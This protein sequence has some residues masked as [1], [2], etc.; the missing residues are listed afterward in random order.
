MNFDDPFDRHTHSSGLR[1]SDAEREQA[2][3]A[4]RRSHTEGRLNDAEFEQ[5]VAQAYSA[6]SRAELE[7]LLADLPSG[8]PAVSLDAGRGMMARGRPHHLLPL[9]VG[10][11]VGLWLLRSLLFAAPGPYWH[12][13]PPFIVPLV[14][15]FLVWRLIAR[16]RRAG[17]PRQWF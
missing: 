14:V 6:R 3:D 1:A 9:V 7:Q 2:A 13:P 4:L 15:L 5:R 8:R 10:A 17:G 16:R 12:G 11:I